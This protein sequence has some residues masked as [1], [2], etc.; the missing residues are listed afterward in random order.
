MP[1]LQSEC[2]VPSGISTRQQIP[3]PRGIR[4]DGNVA[5]IR[6]VGT[7]F[8]T[9]PSQTFTHSSSTTATVDEVWAALDRPETWEAIGGV[10]RVFDAELDG[11][12]RLQGFSFETAA[13]GKSYTGVASPHRRIEGE[14]MAW[15][16]KSSEIRGI[17]EV[18]LDGDA[19]ITRVTVTLQVES[20][21]FLSSMFFP[22][23]A[24]TIGKGMPE[25]VDEFVAGLAG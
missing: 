15:K 24:K 20:A 9:V 8:S 6:L 5:P 11:E 16:V 19:D 25:A 18:H 21:G 2:Q 7:K 1:W 12:G 23:I 13:A 17:T 4:G 10:D 14:T 3:P 22:V